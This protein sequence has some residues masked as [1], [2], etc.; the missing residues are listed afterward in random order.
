MKYHSFKTFSRVANTYNNLRR[1]A[2]AR[3]V[4]TIKQESKRTTNIILS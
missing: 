3:R 2:E 4:C 1:V